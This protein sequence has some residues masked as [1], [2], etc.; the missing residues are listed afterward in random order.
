M[1][2]GENAEEISSEDPCES[3][4]ASNGGAEQLDI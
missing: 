1:A 2:D 4:S 3:S